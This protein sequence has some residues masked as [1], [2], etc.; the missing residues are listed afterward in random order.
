MKKVLI[1]VAVATLVMAG[2][3]LGFL[4]VRYGGAVRPF[5][6]TTTAPLLS[7]ETV[8]VVAELDE[9]PGNIA[10]SPDGRVFFN[11]HPEGRPS[12]KVVEWVDG[13]AV[14]F[15]DEGFPLFDAVFSLRIDLQGRLWTVDHGFH[16]LRQPR[17][18]ATAGRKAQ[19]LK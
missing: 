7:S 3:L 5:P 6:D 17:L 14:P 12:R 19:G 2:L 15:P 18:L 11:F 10:V 1:R 9:A 16:G 4:K 13:K 8:E